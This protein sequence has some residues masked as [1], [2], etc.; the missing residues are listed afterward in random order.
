MTSD[1]AARPGIWVGE[2]FWVLATSAR[3]DDA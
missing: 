2:L 3:G 1:A